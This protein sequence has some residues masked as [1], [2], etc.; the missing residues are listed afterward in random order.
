MNEHK[1]R[2]L[3]ASHWIVD[4]P[5]A[6]PTEEE[7]AE[8]RKVEGEPDPMAAIGWHYQQVVAPPIVADD[9]FL[10]GMT[11]TPGSLNIFCGPRA[12]YAS[13]PLTAEQRAS[14]KAKN[15]RRAANRFRARELRRQAGASALAPTVLPALAAGPAPVLPGPEA[16]MLAA[17]RESARKS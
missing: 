2:G 12:V 6:E 11:V 1:I 13:F 16:D 9:A 15:K 17:I 14:R 10:E 4:D 5:H 8:I 3:R 7:L